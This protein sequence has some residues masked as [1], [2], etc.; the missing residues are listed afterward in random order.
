[1]SEFYI[2]SPKHTLKPR[3]H[4]YI[5]FFRPANAGYAWPLSWAGKY[6]E[7]EVRD[8][9][10]YLSDGEDTLAIPYGIVDAIAVQPKK[11][12]IDGDAGPVVLNTKENWAYL[13]QHAL[14]VQPEAA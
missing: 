8:P 7:A 14:I 4:G 12:D 3:Q 5:T 13:R 6:E 2:A 11:G 1:M 9:K 10:Q